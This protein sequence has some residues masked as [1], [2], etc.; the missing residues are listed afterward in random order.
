[1]TKTKIIESKTC[2]VSPFPGGLGLKI[3]VQLI[4]LI[5]PSLTKILGVIGDKGNINSLDLNSLLDLDIDVGKLVEAM[6][7]AMIELCSRM[8]DEQKVLDLVHQ[9]LLSCTV[10]G[11]EIDEAR[12]NV[13]FMGNYGL[14][15]KLLK[16][17]VEVNYSSFLGSKGF[18]LDQSNQNQVGQASG[19]N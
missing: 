2:I 7:E 15:F 3:L 12:F 9:L 16:F 19:Q 18:S 5:G 4:K 17:V 10:D 1:M 11:V 14:L 13:V 8:E 6:D